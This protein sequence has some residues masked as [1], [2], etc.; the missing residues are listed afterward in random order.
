[1]TREDVPELVGWELVG[2]ETLFEEFSF[3]RQ[4][5]GQGSGASHPGH[6]SLD[7]K[8]LIQVEPE[9]RGAHH[10]AWNELDEREG[11]SRVKGTFDV[12]AGQIERGDSRAALVL[13]VEPNV[14]V[15]AYTDELDCVAVLKFP[16][17]TAKTFN[18]RPGV[19]LITCN[20]YRKKDDGVVRDLQPCD[21]ASKRWQNFHPVIGSFLSSDTTR[22]Q[23]LID[24]IDDGEWQR[25]EEQGAE[26]LI[27]YDAG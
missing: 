3:Y 7:I 8:L 6:L 10:D 23:K 24:E 20:Y 19:R 12:V 11:T 25:A 15:A 9:L 26:W 13:R 4:P 2:R 14:L 5:V 1:M 17:R 18:L 27:R 21:K 22:L 16:A